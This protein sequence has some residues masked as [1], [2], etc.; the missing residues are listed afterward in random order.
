M[1]NTLEETLAVTFPLVTTST[2]TRPTKSCANSAS[3]TNVDCSAPRTDARLLDGFVGE[4]IKS[5]CQSPAIIIGHPKVISPPAKRH[6]LCP[7]LCERFEGFMGGKEFCNAYTACYAYTELN[8]PFGQRLTLEEPGDDEARVVDETHQGGTSHP[9]YEAT[10]TYSPT[11]PGGSA[12]GPSG[13]T[14]RPRALHATMQNEPYSGKAP[15]PAPLTV[16]SGGSPTLPFP[17]AAL[18]A[19]GRCSKSPS[20]PVLAISLDLV[21]TMESL[22]VGAV[23]SLLANLPVLLSPWNVHIS[24]RWL[25]LA[26][27][28]R[29]FCRKSMTRFIRERLEGILQLATDV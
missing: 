1:I 26:L 29:S 6:R 3:S 9:F 18:P 27:R 17:P 25:G 7:G 28:Y 14:S 13:Q 10:G 5:L 22:R 8:D 21:P 24:P 11:T 15:A 4:F 16:D 2:P 19:T 20:H 23:V 12:L